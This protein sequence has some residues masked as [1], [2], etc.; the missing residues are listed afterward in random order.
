MERAEKKK[1]K[2]AKRAAKQRASTASNL[3]RKRS[4]SLANFSTASANAMVGFTSSVTGILR[5][6]STLTRRH[7]NRSQGRD[8]EDGVEPVQAEA[9]EMEPL[10][11]STCSS[12]GDGHISFTTPQEPRGS[13]STNSETS[14]TSATPSVHMPRSFA[15][16]LTLP[17]TWLHISLRRVQHAHQDATKKQAL[18]RAERRQKVYARPIEGGPAAMSAED[19][20]LTNANHIRTERQR[21]IVEAANEEG[22]G[23]GWGLGRF[24][25]Q[26]QRDGAARLQAVKDQLQEER[27]LSP[28]EEENDAGPSA[29]PTR[30]LDDDWEDLEDTTSSGSGNVRGPGENQTIVERKKPPDRKDGSGTGWSWWGPLKDWR[31]SDRSVF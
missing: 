13:H 10:R 24:G 9:I 12:Q 14:S 3:G 19:A 15:Q 31:L 30:P 17:T 6:H 21:A 22:D 29:T 23:V 26:E 27:L 20:V 18:D 11:P 4:S 28:T 1:R 8:V 25:V 16:L 5:S 7:T 2:L